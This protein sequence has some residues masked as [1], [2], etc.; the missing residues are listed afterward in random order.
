MLW[1]SDSYPATKRRHTT[2]MNVRGIRLRK[3]QPL[4]DI[5]EKTR[6]WDGGHLSDLRVGQGQDWVQRGST[7]GVFG[8]IGMFCTPT[9]VLVM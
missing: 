7:K 3:R 6:F 9:A 5:L 1:E 8:A 4:Y 2:W